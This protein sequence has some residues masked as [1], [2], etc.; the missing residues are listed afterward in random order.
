MFE[1]FAYQHPLIK[2][3]GP[4]GFIGG[5]PCICKDPDSTGDWLC[6]LEGSA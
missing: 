5:V 2:R 1:V 4:V 3:I 6:S